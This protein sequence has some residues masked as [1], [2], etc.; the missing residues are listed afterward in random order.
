MM[1]YNMTVVKSRPEKQDTKLNSF[2]QKGL[3][4]FVEG[5]EFQSAE[6]EEF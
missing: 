4:E 6:Y 2:L 3:Q 5:P 1:K